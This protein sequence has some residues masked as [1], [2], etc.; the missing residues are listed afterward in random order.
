VDGQTLEDG[1]VTIR[2]RDTMRQERIGE[3]R[4]AEWLRERI[5]N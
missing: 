3:E 1:T 2:D 5:E 4:V